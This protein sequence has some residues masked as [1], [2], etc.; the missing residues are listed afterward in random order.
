MKSIATVA[1]V[2]FSTYRE[3]RRC[4]VVFTIY[5][6]FRYIEE[7]K[8]EHDNSIVLSKHRDISDIPVYRPTLQQGRIF[9]SED[10][11]VLLEYFNLHKVFQCMHAHLRVIMQ[12]SFCQH[13]TQYPCIYSAC[14]CAA[15]HKV[16]SLLFHRFGKSQGGDLCMV[17]YTAIQRSWGFQ[18]P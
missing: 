4:I 6:V 3:W 13:L 17:V 7:D 8:N 2:R 1:T 16:R 12:V 10:M 18:N 14:I 9:L 11:N 5:R 15:E